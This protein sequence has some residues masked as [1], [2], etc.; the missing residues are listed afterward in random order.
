MRCYAPMSTAEL[1]AFVES[2]RFDVSFLYV[3]SDA[4][5]VEYGVNDEEEIEYAA[6]EVARAAA[7]RLSKPFIVALDVESEVVD[8]A[9]EASAGVIEGS[10]EL[11]YSDVVALY[12]ITGPDDELEWYDASESALCIAQSVG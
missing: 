5:S 6:Q 11:N 10:F 9:V 8:R 12:L 7:E 4:L 2:S 1:N 3:P